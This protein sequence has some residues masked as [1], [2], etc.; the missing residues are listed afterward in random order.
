VYVCGEQL[1]EGAGTVRFR[2]AAEQGA[3]VQI[4][5]HYFDG[6]FGEAVLNRWVN[7]IS[8]LLIVITL[9]VAAL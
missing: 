4:G 2:V 6:Y 7:P 8:I 9:G 3:D 5:G 1:D